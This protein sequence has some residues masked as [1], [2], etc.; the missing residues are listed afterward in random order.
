MKIR[1]VFDTLGKPAETVARDQTVEAAIG[2]MANRKT[3]AL[4][5]TEDGHPIGIFTERDVFRCCVR[6]RGRGFSEI[7]V[8]EAMT[9]KLISASAEDDIE[10]LLTVMLQADIRHLPV[11]DKGLVCGMLTITDLARSVLE[12]LGHEIEHLHGYI[13]DL[14]EARKD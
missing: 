7:R 2:R 8:D 10:G 3:G 12:F 4:L 5:V 1:E 11:M 13:H 9:N 6:N 14:Q